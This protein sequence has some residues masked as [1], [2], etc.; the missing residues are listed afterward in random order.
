MFSWT[1]HTRY[2]I[3]ARCTDGNEATKS[4][5]VEYHLGKL[6]ETSHLQGV[7]WWEA[8]QEGPESGA[9]PPPGLES[10]L[11]VGPVMVISA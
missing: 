11:S 3:E 10:L 7:Y 2:D 5:A 1:Y 8:S 9:I 4:D 6:G